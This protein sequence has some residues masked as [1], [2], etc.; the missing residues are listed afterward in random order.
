VVIEQLTSEGFAQ[1]GDVISFE[2]AQHYL[3]NNGTTERYHD[4]AHVDVT[5]EGGRP[6]ISLFRSKPRQLPFTVRLMERHPLGSQAFFPLSPNPYLVI[7][8][9][10]GD[11]DVAGV[12]VFYASPSQGVNY[13][14]GVWHHALFALKEVSDFFIV[15]R[16]ADEPNCDEIELTKP[17]T[18]SVEAMRVWEGIQNR[19]SISE[20]SSG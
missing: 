5:T 7:V 12:R 16:G 1:F 20:L 4:L 18:I 13:A 9:P 15:D 6:L 17:L 8:A 10:L 11:L 2:G 14:K 19:E 3:I